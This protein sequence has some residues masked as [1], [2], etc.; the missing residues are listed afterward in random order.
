MQC[1]EVNEI[2]GFKFSEEGGFYEE[3][4]YCRNDWFGVRIGLFIV[5]GGFRKTCIADCIEMCFND[6]ERHAGCA[7]F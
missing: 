6:T 3:V 1:G 5:Y 2:D 4:T 7:G